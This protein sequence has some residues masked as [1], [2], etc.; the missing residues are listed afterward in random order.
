[1]INIFIDIGSEKTISCITKINNKEH[2]IL[3]NM[4]TKS[5]KFTSINNEIDIKTSLSHNLQQ[6]KKEFN[7]VHLISKT[8]ISVPSSLVIKR[9]E[10]FQIDILSKN[11]VSYVDINELIK[12]AKKK[13]AT[14]NKK[15]I[16]IIPSEYGINGDEGIFN[17]IGK[18]GN[19]LEAKLLIIEIDLSR[20]SYIEDTCKQLGLPKIEVFLDSYAS[21]FAVLSEDEKNDGSVLIDFGAAKTCIMF[22]HKKIMI[23][24]HNI[25]IGFATIIDDLVNE[26]GLSNI[27]AIRVRNLYIMGYNQITTNTN[28]ANDFG[29]TIKFDSISK[30]INKR[31]NQIVKDTTDYINKIPLIDICDK[32]I[33]ITGGASSTPYLKKAIAQSIGTPRISE[34]KQFNHIIGDNENPGSYATI[35]GMVEM[36]N[37]IMIQDQEISTTDRFH[38]FLKKFINW[39]NN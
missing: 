4:V 6:I 34:L 31:V 22:F 38:L 10:S 35:F 3:K 30:I 12:K 37:E 39:L 17:P 18:Q 29:K 11:T 20:Y 36:Q 9:Y 13:L 7:K 24:F 26:F 27:E 33:V 1:M 15:I 32:N 8:F 16:H 14:N 28:I 23:Y 2:K 25:N 19:I 5:S 21:S